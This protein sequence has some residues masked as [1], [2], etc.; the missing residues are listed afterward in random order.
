M[1]DERFPVMF[2]LAVPGFFFVP[3]DNLLGGD[4]K[5]FRIPRLEPLPERFE[6]DASGPVEHAR[7]IDEV[8]GEQASEVHEVTGR[9][10]LKRQLPNRGVAGLV[11]EADAQPIAEEA[12]A[13]D[14][15]AIL[16]GR[17]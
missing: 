10:F 15:R 7:K 12:R 3:G 5:I 2:D 16:Q 13:L 14:G 11:S 4:S 6:R 8:T 17:A 1:K 9:F